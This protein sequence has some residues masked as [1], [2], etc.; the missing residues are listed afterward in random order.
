M[1]AL[2]GT[3]Q[4]KKWS[5]TSLAAVD[6]PLY[7]LR[8]KTQQQTTNMAVLILYPFWPKNLLLDV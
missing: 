3:K 8:E 5:W 4:N 1:D 2:Y 7:H 6:M